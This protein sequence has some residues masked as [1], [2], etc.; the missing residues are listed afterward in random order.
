MKRLNDEAKTKVIRMINEIQPKFKY[1]I[2]YRDLNQIRLRY[3]YKDIS[4]A[5]FKKDIRT[6][7]LIND[8]SLK[9]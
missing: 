1:T 5:E 6:I 3:I 9:K 8:I 2:Y 4:M 7:K